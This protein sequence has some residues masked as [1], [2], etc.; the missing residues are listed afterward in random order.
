[1]SAIGVATCPVCFMVQM[2]GLAGAVMPHQSWQV[3]QGRLGPIP[4]FREC[5]GSNRLPAD[6]VSPYRIAP[7]LG[8][9]GVR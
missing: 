8:G 3:E 5:P 9:E 1:M 6:A 7:P 4:V 2:R